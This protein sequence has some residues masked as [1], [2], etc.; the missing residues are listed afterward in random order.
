MSWDDEDDDI[1]DANDLLAPDMEDVGALIYDASPRLRFAF[2][3]LH[4]L[5]EPTDGPVM[6]AARQHMVR[7][8]TRELDE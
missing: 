2:A 5:N 6:Q 8:L 3:C 4:S 7:Y 1:M